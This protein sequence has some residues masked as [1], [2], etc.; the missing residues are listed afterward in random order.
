MKIFV[1]VG[2]TP[3]D[4]LIGAVD[5]QLCVNHEVTSQISQGEYKPVNHEFFEFSDH[6]ET[7]FE[8]AD[9]IISHGGA[10][11]IYRLLEMGKKLVIVP[12]LERLD[13]HQQD[14]CNY[15]EKNGHALAC[16]DLNELSQ[17]VERAL[18]FEFK[19]FSPVPFSGIDEIRAYLGLKK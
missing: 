6:V 8:D 14:I 3:F 9:L 17:V 19:Q 16:E 11:S 2:T 12:N 10:G 7:Y 15:M 1:T 13:A 4:S 5:A 18:A